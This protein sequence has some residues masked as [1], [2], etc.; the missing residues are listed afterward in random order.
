[1]TLHE[2]NQKRGEL[3]KE[4]RETNDKAKAEKREMTAIESERFDKIMEEVDGLDEQRD[5]LLKSDKRNKF[6]ADQGKSEGRKSEPDNGNE[7]SKKK[8]E[9]R[10]L[11]WGE[12]YESKRE[13]KLS[14]PYA[15]DEY[16]AAH[17]KWLAYG[18]QALSI[19]EYRALQA[20]SDTVGGYI[21]NPVQMVADLIKFVDNM[22]FVR[23]K[24]TVFSVPTAQSL[25]A[26]SLDTDMSAPDWTAEILTGSEDSSI[27][28]GRRELNPHPLA[29]LIKVSNTLLRKAIM[30]PEALVRDRL[31]YQVAITLENAYLNGTG[32]NQPLGLFTA[33]NN[34]VSTARDVSTGNSTTA[35][36][37]DNL[38]EVKYSL[39]QQH[40]EQGEW[41]FHRSAVK[42]IRKLKDGNGQY[43][44]APGLI[45]SQPNT[46]LDRPV[47]MSEY[48][49]STFTTGLYVGLFGNL[50][51]Y[52]IADALSLQIQRLVELYA[53]T[54]Q[55]G[56][57]GRV[58]TDG[59]PVLDEAFAR[60][61]LA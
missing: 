52:W 34:G 27:A 7:G 19:E 31:G 30:G 56:F 51:Y 35:I 15:T 26:P 23:Q 49:P 37:A 48:A 17:A 28:F 55:T 42:A 50:K 45:A 14:G 2:I 59:A 32:S 41:I 22:V 57:I 16:R 18:S 47:N 25:G 6:L 38:F 8:D 54:N 24:C 53:A 1:M 4:A 36:A 21:T 10:T 39:K 9:V 3:W 29:K 33:S 43:L 12:N 44:W 13:I 46:L 40:Q 20:D 5:A 61:K 60:V 58:E 11:T